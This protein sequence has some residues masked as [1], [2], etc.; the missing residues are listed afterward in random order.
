[1]GYGRKMASA[2]GSDAAAANGL[3]GG[4]QRAAYAGAGSAYD[5]QLAMLDYEVKQRK[6]QAAAQALSQ[7]AMLYM[8]RRNGG[9]MG[10]PGL[11]GMAPPATFGMGQPAQGG[12]PTPARGPKALSLYVER[13]AE[14]GMLPPES[15]TPTSKT[16]K[17]PR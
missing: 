8:M 17:G 9:G 16:P 4:V 1:M 14:M 5:D 7:M 2:A 12:M 3:P 15:P 10:Q 11:N 6:E 13:M